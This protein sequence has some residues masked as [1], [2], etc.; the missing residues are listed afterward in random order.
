MKNLLK[1]FVCEEQ[2]QD[3]VEYVLLAAT[4]SLAILAGVQGFGT[5][6]YGLYDDLYNRVAAV[7]P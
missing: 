6:M 3:I 7:F 4:I 5:R 2:G 1:R